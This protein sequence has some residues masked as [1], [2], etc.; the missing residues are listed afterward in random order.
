MQSQIS[1]DER[2]RGLSRDQNSDILQDEN[3][4]EEILEKI[5]NFVLQIFYPDTAIC[6]RI[7]GLQEDG[8]SEEERL[9][10]HNGEC[11]KPD[12]EE[13]CP[14]LINSGLVLFQKVHEEQSS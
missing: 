2:L 9:I 6:K 7:H 14:P 12:Q 5:S 13:I 1:K 8:S 11:H 3:D 10:Q 4:K